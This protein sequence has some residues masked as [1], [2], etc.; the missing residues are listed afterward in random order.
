MTGE[1]SGYKP[2]AAEME[3]PAQR[4]AAYTRFSTAFSEAFTKNVASVKTSG[5]QEMLEL[6]SAQGGLLHLE[7]SMTDGAK[8]KGRLWY[9]EGSSAEYDYQLHEYTIDGGIV[10]ETTN[11]RLSEKP[12]QEESNPF[13]TEGDSQ[14]RFNEEGDSQMKYNRA[15]DRRIQVTTPKPISAGEANRISELL[16]SASPK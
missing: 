10:Y 5:D 14:M 13:P 3:T 4:E 1:E 11:K 9:D 12:P 15:M 6:T 7:R 2:P 8:T 16:P